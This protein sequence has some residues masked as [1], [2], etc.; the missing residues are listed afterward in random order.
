MTDHC[1]TSYGA[2]P[3]DDCTDAIERAV[4]ACELTGG[5]VVVPDGVFVT[6]PIRLRSNVEL[7]LAAGAT[8][9]FRT[10]PSAYP[11][12]RTRWQGIECFSH[13][14]LIYAYDEVNV[15]VTG[16]GT[17]DGG[18][19]DGQLVGRHQA[20]RRLEPPAADGL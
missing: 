20:G 18:A 10:D 4:R 7:H 6:G 11:I 5:R 1:I 13:S 3:D 16:T 8:L 15:A 14:P 2:R 17:L 9:R 19:G 12:V